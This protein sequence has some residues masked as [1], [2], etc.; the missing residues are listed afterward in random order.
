[1]V[2]DPLNPSYCLSQPTDPATEPGA[3]PPADAVIDPESV[4][5]AQCA[6]SIPGVQGLIAQDRDGFLMT[7]EVAKNL[8]ETEEDEAV[9]A[10]IARLDKAAVDLP[11]A[12]KGVKVAVGGEHLILTEIV[13]DM[14]HDLEVGELISLP[15]ALIVMVLVFAG[16]LAAAMPVVGAV[17]SILTCMGAVFGFTYLTDIHTSVI[18]VISLV[19]IGLSIDY[20]L[21]IVSRFREEIR[22][23]QVD[24]IGGIGGDDGGG[25]ADGAAARSTRRGRGQAAVKAAVTTTVETAGR[26]VF[27]SAL[28]IA[29]CVAGLI[30]FEP[31]ILRTFGLA[32]LT[33]VLLAL[34]TATTLVPALLVLT[35]RWLTKPSLISRIPGLSYIYKKA[36]DVSPDTGIFSKL[37]NAVQRRPW[38]VMG[39]VLVVMVVLAWPIIGIE[40]RN[41][42]VDLLPASSPQRAFLDELEANYPLSNADAIEVVSLGS[43]EETE[44][45]ARDELG[46]I[47]GTELA[48]GLDGAAITDH[49]SYV[50]IT[51]GVTGEDPEG[52]QARTAVERIR[53]KVPNGFEV[54]VT[55][56][57]ARLLDFEDQLAAGAPTALIIVVVATFI[58]LF[59]FTGSVLIPIKALI[60]NALS[61]LACLGV[62]TWIFQGGHFAGLLGFT[63]VSGIESYILVLLLIFGFGLAMDYE[64]FL[65]SRIKE[66]WDSNLD[67]RLSVSEGLQHSGRI[68]T[69]AALIIVM[70]FL[71]FAAGR[72]VVIKEI[73]LGLALAVALDATLVRMLLVPATMSVLGKWNWWAPRPLARLHKRLGL[74]H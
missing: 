67:P 20:G 31:S 63:A 47:E 61:L 68:I 9:R 42:T 28:T 39:G 51:L 54:H 18:N 60:S 21:L 64:V 71:G 33:V 50:S 5:A 59:L 10:I 1:M 58:L 30:A 26:T 32:S 29:V 35:G 8:G 7:A 36:S 25:D 74:S 62:V 13:A 55:G 2:I 56:P 41:S 17:A 23:A 22:R 70:V 69:S 6:L 34:G 4:E 65:I 12:I 15:V 52:P 66:S 16:F 38:W 19:G 53:E 27:Y 44:A 43:P 45:F 48:K 73:G 3:N 49:D 37:A 24:G 46:S 57:A 72:L 14:K 40:L 11:K